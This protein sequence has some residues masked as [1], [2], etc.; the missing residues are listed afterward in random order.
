MTQ[1]ISARAAELLHKITTAHETRKQFPD[2]YDE[3]QSYSEEIVD[4]TMALIELREGSE[5]WRVECRHCDYITMP[6][7]TI[8]EAVAEVLGHEQSAHPPAL[9]APA[10]APASAP[11]VIINAPAVPAEELVR[12]T[13]GARGLQWAR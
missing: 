9:Q 5:E 13:L 6:R 12:Q 10:P 1:H 4:A 7:E 8:G 11:V 2:F 3:Y